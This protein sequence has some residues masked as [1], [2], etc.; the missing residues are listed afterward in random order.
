MMYIYT[1]S[2][3]PHSSTQTPGYVFQLLVWSL[4]ELGD[5]SVF[6]KGLVNDIL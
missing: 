2:F 1:S 3:L 4:Y 6:L 5:L